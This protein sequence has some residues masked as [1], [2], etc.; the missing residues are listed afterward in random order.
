MSRKAL[1]QC[2][3]ERTPEAQRRTGK[4]HTV[5]PKRRGGK[6]IT[7]R[8]HRTIK[9]TGNSREVRVFNPSGHTEGS[10]SPFMPLWSLYSD[11]LKQRCD[12]GR[13]PKLRAPYSRA[14]KDYKGNVENDLSR[15]KRRRR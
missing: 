15:A 8:K 2:A 14:R 6:Q 5:L 4:Q 7:E 10:M 1:E 11:E 12:G 9:L 3:W 13:E